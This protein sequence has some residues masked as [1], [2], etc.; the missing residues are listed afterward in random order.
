MAAVSKLPAN[1]LKDLSPEAV[2]YLQKLEKQ[3]SAAPDLSG[4]TVPA[5]ANTTATVT[6]RTVDDDLNGVAGTDA[7]T[8]PISIGNS[9]GTTVNDSFT[10]IANIF[11]AQYLNDANLAAAIVTLSDRLNAALAVIEDLRAAVADE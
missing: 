7:G 1:W 2:A 10:I 9:G 6:T 5:E 11:N 8:D 3:A 4:I